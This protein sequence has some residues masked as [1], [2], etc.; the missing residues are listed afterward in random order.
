LPRPIRGI[1][2]DTSVLAG[3]G[4]KLV[5]ALIA[6]GHVKG[7]WSQWIAMELGRTRSERKGTACCS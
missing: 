4:S 6:T 2:V 3:E 5:I 1:V 7:Y